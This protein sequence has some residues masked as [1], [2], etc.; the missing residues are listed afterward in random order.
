M[1][2]ALSVRLVV[3]QSAISVICACVVQK[4]AA[5]IICAAGIIRAACARCASVVPRRIHATRRDAEFLT[6]DYKRRGE[7]DAWRALETRGSAR[8]GGRAA[9]RAL[10]G[11]LRASSRDATI[12]SRGRCP[13]WQS[14][15]EEAVADKFSMRRYAMACRWERISANQIFWNSPTSTML[16]TL[17]FISGTAQSVATY[18]LF[19]I[20]TA[21]RLKGD[22]LSMATVKSND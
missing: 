7:S 15:R 21:I 5:S 9:R 18:A 19:W 4:G 20:E 2:L 22:A 6:Y 16:L 13:V 1:R 17:D 11:A 8:R 3:C 14:Q 12:F 10:V